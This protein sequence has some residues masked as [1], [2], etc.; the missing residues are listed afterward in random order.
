ME[1]E[2]GATYYLVTYADPQLSMP[3]LK[4]MVYIGD[5]LFGEDSETTHYFQDTVSV[6]IFGLVG[7]AKETTDCRVSSFSHDEL[8]D[9]IVD[10]DGAAALVASAAKKFRKLGSPKLKKASGSLNSE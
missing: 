2:Y 6:L 3:G 9:S 8:G 7:E 10:I 4:P 1:L 5:N